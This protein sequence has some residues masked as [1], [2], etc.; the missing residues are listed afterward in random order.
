MGVTP[1]RR[2]GV[3]D[4]SVDPGAGG[5]AMATVGTGACRPG[6]LDPGELDPPEPEEDGDDDGRLTE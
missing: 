1:S 5:G 3:I 2:Q 4:P 6:D